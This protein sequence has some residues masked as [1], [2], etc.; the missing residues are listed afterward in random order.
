MKFARLI[1]FIC[2]GTVISSA[3]FAANVAYYASFNAVG[4][5]NVYPTQT[6]AVQGNANSGDGGGGVFVYDP[7]TSNIACPLVGGVAQG[8]NGVS[9][10]DHNHVCFRRVFSG[11][12]DLRWY[13]VSDAASQSCYQSANY[14]GCDSWGVIDR[15]FIVSRAFGDGGVTTGGRSIAILSG[16]LNIPPTQYL[17]CAGPPGA[18]RNQTSSDLK[19]YQLPNSI[20]LQSPHQVTTVGQSRFTDCLIRPSWYYYSPM[21]TP[22]IPF[23]KPRDVINAKHMFSGT[24]YNCQGEGCIVD[25]LFVF[26]F[27][28]CLE[29]GTLA[30]G[31]TPRT[32]ADTLWLECN[33]PVAVL[34]QTGGIE[35][36]NIAIQPY[37]EQRTHDADNN[38]ITT[39][40]WAIKKV[41]TDV[42][43]D[44]IK[45]TIQPSGGASPSADVQ[46]GDTV[47]VSGMGPATMYPPVSATGVVASGATTISDIPASTDNSDGWQ[48]IGDGYQVSGGCLG[49][50]PTP[51][52]VYDIRE[53][54]DTGKGIATISPAAP[55]GCSGHTETLNWIDVAASTPGGNGA[56]LV[57]GVGSDSDG[58]Y[59]VLK[60]A[61]WAGPTFDGAKWNAGSSVIKLYDTT[62][63]AAGA[64]LCTPA[65]ASAAPFCTPPTGFTFAS[66]GSH[67]TTSDIFS[68]GTVTGNITIA[69]DLTG[70]PRIGV[71]KVESEDLCYQLNS[72]THI[73]VTCRGY[74]GTTVV[75]HPNSTTLTPAA[76]QVTGVIPTPNENAVI[77]SAQAQTGTAASPQ[78]VTFANDVT[79]FSSVLGQMIIN[80]GYGTTTAFLSAGPPPDGVLTVH[81]SASSTTSPDC[82]GSPLSTVVVNANGFKVQKGM[83]VADVTLGNGGNF[84]GNSIVCSVLSSNTFTVSGPV[85]GFSD[86]LVQFSGCGF[87]P[88]GSFWLGNC[89]ATGLLNTG[90]TSDDLSQGMTCE[91]FHVFGLR[92]ALHMLGGPASRCTNYVLSGGSG[93]GQ[94]NDNV[95]TGFWFTGDASKSQFTNGRI[96]GNLSILNVPSRERDGLEISNSHVSANVVNGANGNMILTGT[97]R[98]GSANG[99]TFIYDDSASQALNLGS[100]S[101]PDATVHTDDPATIT[102]SLYCAANNFATALCSQ[103]KGVPTCISGCNAT[104][105][106]VAGTDSNFVVNTDGTSS[107][108]V[109]TLAEIYAPAPAP[110]VTGVPYPAAPVCTASA[111]SSGNAVAASVSSVD[112][113]FYGTKVTFKIGS[114]SLVKQLFAS[115]RSLN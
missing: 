109:V 45:L 104:L 80:A 62:N 90:S 69:G 28:I 15:A 50:P 8:D 55:P 38:K 36:S 88:D 47:L 49:N 18:Y 105:P 83:A 76:P 35:L 86:N 4:N 94:I 26:G 114:A 75:T 51:F 25:R 37:L 103:A 23:A 66:G 12:V 31:S 1:S 87:P 33:V 53:D 65:T 6:I 19:Y 78:S 100:N 113:E 46:V 9:V 84:A 63:V 10:T 97:A 93:N 82:F 48:D 71:L 61:S 106:N 85:T 30:G 64:Y 73:K 3:A 107:S 39:T 14:S 110:V 5:A 54:D 11:P 16:D 29:F 40:Q 44:D 13:G 101:Y 77:V 99:S 115:C 43:T 102:A 41:K 89:V 72:A 57:S 67:V 42:G 56:W 59:A 17:T 21:G 52:I 98:K 74:D 68:L 34:N 20:V 70:W 108:I 92:V 2:V 111:V 81:A 32:V 58:P 27:D 79:V 7:D 91:W 96:V 95:S 22:V 24:A 60:G 112:A